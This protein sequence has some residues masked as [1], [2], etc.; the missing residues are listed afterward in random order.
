MTILAICPP[1]PEGTVIGS[2]VARITIYPLG[3]VFFRLLGVAYHVEGISRS[4][5]D[6]VMTVQERKPRHGMKETEDYFS[7]SLALG[8][9]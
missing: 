8:T 9:Q 7:F 4:C 3:E 1:T 6:F 5:E 2:G